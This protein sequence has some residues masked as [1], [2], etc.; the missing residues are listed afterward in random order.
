VEVEDL[1]DELPTSWGRN[2]LMIGSG[3]D[4]VLQEIL[5]GRHGRLPE[6][7]ILV[8]VEPLQG[9]QLAG[10]T[11]RLPNGLRVRRLFLSEP[12]AGDRS[13][14]LLTLLKRILQE[15]ERR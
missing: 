3:T 5:E 10:T 14:E 15:P 7:G 6:H 9:V 8:W 11:P 4:T 13:P 2:D 1:S 12:S